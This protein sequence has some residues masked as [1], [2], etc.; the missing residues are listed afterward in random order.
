MF[1]IISSIFSTLSYTIHLLARLLP[2]IFYYGLIL[3]TMAVGGLMISSLIAKMLDLRTDHAVATFLI[4]A[5]RLDDPWQS[6]NVRN[7]PGGANVG[8]LEQRGQWGR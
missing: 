3:G 5:D 1:S 7:S 2:A 8:H 4:K 6:E